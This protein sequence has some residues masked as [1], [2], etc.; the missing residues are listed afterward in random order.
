VGLGSCAAFRPADADPAVLAHAVAANS[1]DDPDGLFQQAMRLMEDGHYA[2]AC[3]MLAR[4]Q[5]FDSQLGTKLHLAYCLENLGRTA[6]A[7]SLWLEAAAEASA[8]HESERASYARTQ[9]SLLAP[10]LSYVTVVVTEQRDIDRMTVHLDGIVLARDRWGTPLPID[11]GLHWLEAIAPGK[12]FWSTRIDVDE[13]HLPIVTVPVLRGDAP[14]DVVR[15][16]TPWSPR[17]SA[18]VVMG[19]IGAAA[20]VTGAVLLLS[21][22]IQYNALCQGTHCLEAAY[23]ARWHDR[24]D[25]QIAIAV[26]TGG[27]AGLL[28]A[29]LL[30]LAG[31]A[32]ADEVRV[33]PQVD[34]NALG[35]S[36]DG[37]W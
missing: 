21:A 5:E 32:R 16:P 14:A 2:R 37:K 12:N 23:P 36:I 8:R 20:V 33:E 22:S 1:E 3:P 27:G 9:A 29:A 35:L 28:G 31:P 15:R 11:P 17:R 10:R 7:W 30:W 25:A 6:T 18:A 4:S 34:R 13:Q 24:K 26:M 19:G